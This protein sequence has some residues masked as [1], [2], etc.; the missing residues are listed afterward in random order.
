MIKTLLAMTL[1]AVS[2][3]AG[4]MENAAVSVKGEVLEVRD[5]ESYTYLR[6]KTE[7]GETWAAVAKA[8]VRKG[9]QITLENVMVMEN[10]ESKT[11]KKTF[12]TILFGSLGGAQ[13]ATPGLGMATAHAIN[14]INMADIHVP[15]AVGENART[16][17]EIVSKAVELK[18]KP[19]LVRGKIVKYNADIMGK[20]W[21]HLRDGSAANADILVTTSGAAKLGDVVTVK[22]VLRND[23]DFGAGY[24]YKVLIEDADLQP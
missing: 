16:V 19:V 13:S 18:D 10:F 15:R 9:G 21:L 22:G 17:A 12:K 8:R 5:V 6:L 3:F 24:F 2:T 20:N 14:T 4:A 23:K 7:E 1:F 11:L